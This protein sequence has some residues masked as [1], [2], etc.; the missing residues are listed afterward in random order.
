MLSFLR[1]EDL[2]VLGVCTD[3]EHCRK[4][5]LAVRG[6]SAI[7]HHSPPGPASARFSA[8]TVHSGMGGASPELLARA[9]SLALVGADSLAVES[10]DPSPFRRGDGSLAGRV[11]SILVEDDDGGL[12]LCA[13]L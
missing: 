5:V 1:P 2:A 10:L 6:E 8:V 9:E 4:I 11:E 7:F 12:T 3:A 13:S